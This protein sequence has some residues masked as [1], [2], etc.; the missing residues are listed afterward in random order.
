MWINLDSWEICVNNPFVLTIHANLEPLAC[1]TLAVVTYVC[2][3]LENMDIFVKTV[4]NASYLY[5]CIT[6]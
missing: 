1:L 4:I 6:F 2:A 5:E 3:L